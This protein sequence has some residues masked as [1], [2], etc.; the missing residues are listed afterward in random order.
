[1]RRNRVLVAAAGLFL[2]LACLWAR[3]AWLQVFRHS[4]YAERAER[5]QELRVL[6]EPVRGP[7]LDRR[8]RPL[9]RDLLT[10]S[11]S[12]APREMKD[13]RAT[14]RVLARA[15]GLDPARLARAFAARRWF[16]RVARRVP[17][18]RGER[19]ARAGQRGV[20][21]ALETRRE[22]VLGNAAEEI[23]GCTNIDHVGVEGLERMCDEELRGRPGWTTLFR[24]GRG[25]SERARTVA[26]HARGRL[27][28]KMEVV[29]VTPDYYS[30]Y[31]KSCMDGWG[32]RFI[33]VNPEGFALPC[34]LAQ[35]IPGLHF[36]NVRQCHLEEI[37]H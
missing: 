12:A 36:E 31:P 20:Y 14:A 2:G 13:P 4:H 32:R 16:V 5:N 37:W 17:P 26:E 10:Y 15:L 6:L 19:I 27:Q 7:L 1:M 34:H 18:D 8:G 30:V 11:I 21:V 9:A 3:A 29:F 35:T 24:D 28:G 23:L 33:V 22:Y 25:R